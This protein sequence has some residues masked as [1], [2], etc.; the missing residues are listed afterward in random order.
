MVI[1]DGEGE[2]GAGVLGGFEKDGLLGGVGGV[3]GFADHA[4]VGVDPGEEELFVGELLQVICGGGEGEGVEEVVHLGDRLGQGGADTFSAGPEEG[5]VEDVDPMLIGGCGGFDAEAGR[6]WAGAARLRRRRCVRDGEEG[7]GRGS[8]RGGEAAF[9]RVGVRW[10]FS[11][12]MRSCSPAVG[13]DWRKRERKDGGE[14]DH[15]EGRQ[16]QR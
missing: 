5:G 15:G 7:R 3:V 13:G 4:A 16:G 6:R 9:R 8:S 12:A 2:D 11:M 14:E 10:S 1:G